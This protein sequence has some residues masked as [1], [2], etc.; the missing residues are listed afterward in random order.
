M[1]CLSRRVFLRG[2]TLLLLCS[3]VAQYTFSKTFIGLAASQTPVAKRPLRMLVLGDSVM[4]GQGLLDENKFSYRLRNW[5][6]EQRGNAG[7]QNKEDV[8]LHVEA[9]SGA[10]V[11]RPKKKKDKEEEERFTRN[12]APIRFYGEVNNP[13]PTVWGQVDLARRYY[14]NNSI[15]LNE[16]DLIIVNG[17]INDMNASK[18]LVNRLLGGDVKELVKEH[19]KDMKSLLEKVADTFPNARIVVPGYFPLV[20]ESTPPHIIFQTIKEW[21]FSTKEEEEK[22]EKAIEEDRADRSSAPNGARPN[23]LLRELAERSREFVTATNDALGDAVKELNKNRPPLSAV[24]VGSET[25]PT[26]AS[27]RALF[28]PVPFGDNNAYA[29][30]SS[31]L[32][33][34]GKREGRFELKCAEDNVVTRFVVNDQMQNDRPCMCDHAGRKNDLV[35]F[36]AGA[37]H[38]NGDGANAYYES[39]KRRLEGVL[40]Y[41]GWASGN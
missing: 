6:C 13:Y 14:L 20:S 9:H 3:V 23:R 8:H 12:V 15:P 2:L 11:S 32:W 38:P 1:S 31:F 26:E 29:A 33:K 36:R 22:M 7:C 28:V 39:I 4:W 35:C 37:F 40:R 17:G 21:L 27:L 25:P 24:R 16:V 34:L 30:P 5:L 18:L 10:I 19:W 41:T